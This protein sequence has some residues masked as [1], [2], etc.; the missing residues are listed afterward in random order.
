MIYLST[1]WQLQPS[2]LNTPTTASVME[3]EH[4]RRCSIWNKQTKK[5]S[6]KQLTWYS[7]DFCFNCIKCFLFL[8][9]V[10]KV[11][12]REISS[13]NFIT[14]H[15][16]LKITKTNWLVRSTNWSFHG[17]TCAELRHIFPCVPTA[18]GD[19]PEQDTSAGPVTVA[20]DGF[21][22]SLNKLKYLKLVP[23]QTMGLNVICVG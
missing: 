15:L 6:K 18:Q 1:L 7:C 5:P 13:S 19:R 22:Q 11:L 16:L 10:W 17:R 21:G 20:I 14:V 4:L 8:T 12:R 9:I 23:H 2:G 3:A